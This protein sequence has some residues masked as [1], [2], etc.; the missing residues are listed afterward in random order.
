MRF[1]VKL[2]LVLSLVFVLAMA[3][4]DLLSL[5]KSKDLEAELL[6]PPSVQEVI[7]E[8]D[9]LGLDPEDYLERRREAAKEDLTELYEE[10]MDDANDRGVERLEAQ[11]QRALERLDEKY[12]QRLE[13]LLARLEREDS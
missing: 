9:K 13:R 12:D 4:C 3:G 7:D 6:T 10:R 1:G 2:A 8:A 11:L 5:D